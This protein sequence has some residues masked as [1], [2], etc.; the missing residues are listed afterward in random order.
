[1]ASCAPVYPDWEPDQILTPELWLSNPGGARGVDGEKMRCTTLLALLAGVILYLVMGALV[2]GT[3]EAPK[4]RSAFDGL[5]DTKITFL[6]NNSCVTELDFHKLVKVSLYTLST[7]SSHNPT[8]TN[9]VNV[10]TT[11]TQNCSISFAFLCPFYLQR[12][13]LIGDCKSA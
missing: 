7:L 12:P 5:R 13:L 11:L 6:D 3:L 1:M 4:E 2:F 9:C 10:A 8:H